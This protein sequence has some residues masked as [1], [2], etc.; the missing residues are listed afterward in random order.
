MSRAGSVFYLPLGSG[1]TNGDVS[2]EGDP[3]TARGRERYAGYRIIMGEYLETMDI[4]LRRGRTPGPETS[5][6]RGWW[7]RSTRLLRASFC[8]GRDP[9]GQRITFGRADEKPEWREIVGVV[10]DVRHLGLAQPARSRGLRARAAGRR[11]PVDDLRADADLVRGAN[12]VA[13]PGRSTPRSRPP[14]MRWTRTAGLPAPARR[15]ARKR[16][17]G[18]LPV[19]HAAA[20]DLRR[21]SRSVSPWWASTASWPTA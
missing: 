20:H 7:P 9:I 8:R 10:A 19:Q 21:R 17:D 12:C 11:R 16:L 14:C 4:A 13:A 6:A 15:G 18:A 5:K 3:P 2:V 1:Q